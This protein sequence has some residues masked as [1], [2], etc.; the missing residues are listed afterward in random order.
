MRLWVIF[1]ALK[2]ERPIVSKILAKILY[3]INTL[4]YFMCALIPGPRCTYG[5][6]R[7]TSGDHT[8]VVGLGGKCFNVGAIPAACRPKFSVWI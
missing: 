1:L 2:K 4:V 3:I 6:Q 5:G 7:T 8:Q